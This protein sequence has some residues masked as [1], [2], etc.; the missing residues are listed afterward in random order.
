M[1]ITM[2]RAAGYTAYP[3]MTEA[4]AKVEDV[5]ADQFDHCVVACEIKPN[6]YKL[7][8]PTWCPFSSEIWSSAEK[9]QDY[10][11][12]SPRGEELME[13][14]PAPPEDNFV[15]VVSKASLSPSGDLEG[16]FVITGGHYSETN[17]RWSIV[18]NDAQAV[19][20]MFEEWLS[21]LSPRAELVSYKTTD[22]ADVK[23]P[24]VITVAYRVPGYAMASNG[25]L[26]FKL[27]VAQNIV[28]N[29]RLTDFAAAATPV[30]KRNY[31]L[32][33]RSSRQFIFEETLT[34]PQGYKLWSAPKVSATDGAA[35]SFD[36]SSAFKNGSVVT[37]EKLIVKK[38]IIPADEQPSLATSWEAM[39]AFGGELCAAGK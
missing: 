24:F 34:L 6:V 3:A 29:R 8:D 27:P 20:P 17:L 25:A 26:Y 16:T 30:K 4:V 32:F 13:T 2:F 23:T 36:G 11:I 39:K 21:R 37:S 28:S 19:G 31:G 38:K 9:P 5:P 15:K 35:A 18:N 10:D 14:P 12:G 33:L 1:L 22:P 7:Y